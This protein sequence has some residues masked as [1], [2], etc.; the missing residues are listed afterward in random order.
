MTQERRERIRKHLEQYGEATIAE[1]MEIC[2]DCSNMTLWRDLNRLEQEGILRRTHG[3]AVSMHILKNGTE[4]LYSSRAME[5]IPSK[6]AIA[7]LALNYAQPNHSLFF[8]S[9]ST[10]MQ[11]AK[12][13]PDSHYTIITSGT[14]TAIELSQRN[15]CMVTLLGGQI[16]GN[17]LSCS[18]T[19]A[20]IFL[21]AINIDTAIMATSG[22]SIEAGFTSGSISEQRLKRKVVEKARSVVML[23]DVSK[24]S[25]MLPFTFAYL[26]D[27]DVLVC[28]STPPDDICE[29]ISNENVQL[30]TPET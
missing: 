26:D 25:R 20:E 5:N 12:L 9:G 30:I 6:V 22:F 16:S 3:G 17:T 27:I 11:L 13:L 4:G 15:Q 18:G 23:M 2:G 21:D 28:D 8:D 10:V 24:F 1:L 7:E 19:L 29:L 14:N